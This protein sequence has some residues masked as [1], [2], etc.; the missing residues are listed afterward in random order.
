MKK[1]R[2][3]RENQFNQDG[4]QNDKRFSY[5]F[6]PCIVPP[7][8]DKSE[9]FS[10]FPFLQNVWTRAFDALR[11]AEDIYFLGYSFPESDLQALQ[12]FKDSQKNR[13]SKPRIHIVNIDPEVSRKAKS[14]FETSSIHRYGFVEDFLDQF[15]MKNSSKDL[16]CEDFSLNTGLS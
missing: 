12:L 7:V 4:F 2:K 10:N 11:R 13:E 16:K 1:N 15:L 9:F 3:K 8:A 14:L 5:V 6:T